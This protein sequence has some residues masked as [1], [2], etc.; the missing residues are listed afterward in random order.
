MVHAITSNTLRIQFRKL[1]HLRFLESNFEQCFLP[2]S[3]DDSNQRRHVQ[4]C[5]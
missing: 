1:P 3:S 2:E 5:R 4:L